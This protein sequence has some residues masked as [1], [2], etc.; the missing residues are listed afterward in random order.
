MHVPVYGSYIYLIICIFDYTSFLYLDELVQCTVYSNTVI[1][2]LHEC[3]SNEN[4]NKK[5]QRITTSFI[6]SLVI[7][8]TLEHTKIQSKSFTGEFLECSDHVQCKFVE[9]ITFTCFNKIRFNKI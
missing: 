2:E 5:E 1:Y 6:M 4:E 7:S 8:D 9:Y 3:Q